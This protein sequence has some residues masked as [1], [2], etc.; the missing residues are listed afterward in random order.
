MTVHGQKD[1]EAKGGG[2]ESN[3]GAGKG[4]RGVKKPARFEPIEFHRVCLLD[5]AAH[6]AIQ[7]QQVKLFLH[8]AR[9]R[10]VR[11]ERRMKFGGFTDGRC[12]AHWTRA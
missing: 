5:S 6:F 12:L 11:S 3:D 10:T 8:F 2:K 1:L 9:G 4:N 7:S